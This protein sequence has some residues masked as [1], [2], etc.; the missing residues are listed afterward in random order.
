MTRKIT[1]AALYGFD[2]VPLSEH[3][4]GL[5]AGSAGAVGLAAAASPSPASSLGLVPATY[6]LPGVRR[7]FF[8]SS[9][10]GLILFG[11]ALIYF[12]LRIL[13]R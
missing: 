3:G 7:D 1:G 5:Y 4:I 11:A 2:D 9:D 12:D 8:R 13:N 10:F 6:R